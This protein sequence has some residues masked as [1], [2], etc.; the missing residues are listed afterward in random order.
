MSKKNLPVSRTTG[1]QNLEPVEENQIGQQRGETGAVDLKTLV[2]AKPKENDQALEMSLPPCVASSMEAKFNSQYDLTGYEIRGSMSDEN[3]DTAINLILSYCQPAPNV[4][5]LEGITRLHLAYEWFP[6][7]RELHL[8]I[9][10]R[11][12]KRTMM[13]DAL[14][15]RR[16]DDSKHLTLVANAV[17][18]R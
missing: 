7:V 2:A 3:R 1:A 10:W 6:T 12:D 4:D 15:L 9:K 17:K 11:A 16:G 8:D 18:R 14:R 13:L 5:I